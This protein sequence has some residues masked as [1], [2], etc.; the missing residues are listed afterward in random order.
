MTE[1]ARLAFVGIGANLG[2]RAKTIAAAVEQLRSSSGVSSAETSSLIETDPVG[3]VHQPKFLNAV[4]ALTTT[5]TPEQLLA[6][7]LEV[8]RTFGR[9]RHERWGP[10]TLD[11]DL[12]WFE[13]ETRATAELTLPHPRMFERE[14]VLVPLREML[15]RPQFAGATTRTLR[16]Q[17]GPPSP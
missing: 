3:N 1:P 4:I 7:L 16:E 10:R 12:L 5:L 17:L 14:F 6:R 13:G 11:L 9:V 2:D 8:E 15:R